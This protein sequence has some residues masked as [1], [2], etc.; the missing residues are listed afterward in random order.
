MNNPE[1]ID[2]TSYLKTNIANTYNYKIRNIMID[3]QVK[4]MNR[5]KMR[6]D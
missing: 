6:K 3:E 2:I 1:Y 4:Y 5:L